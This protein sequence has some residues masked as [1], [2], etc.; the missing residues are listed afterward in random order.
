MKALGIILHR[1]LAWLWRPRPEA[2]IEQ[3]RAEWDRNQW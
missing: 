1:W 2:R 3:D